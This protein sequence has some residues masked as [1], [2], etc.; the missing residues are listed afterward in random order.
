MNSFP[1]DAF[2]LVLSNMTGLRL[3]PL[4]EKDGSEAENEAC[5]VKIDSDVPD[6]ASVKIDCDAI[7]DDDIPPV[8]DATGCVSFRKFNFLAV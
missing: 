5:D 7:D 6:D 8:D 2:C 3:H 4:A 1:T